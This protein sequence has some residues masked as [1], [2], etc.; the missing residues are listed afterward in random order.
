MLTFL[1]KDGFR[2]RPKGI[3]SA[4]SPLRMLALPAHTRTEVIWRLESDKGLRSIRED[5]LH[6]L[7]STRGEDPAAITTAQTIGLVMTELAGNALRHGKPPVL[8]RLL[9]DDDCHLLLDV[10]DRAI[11]RIPRQPGPQQSLSAGG[12]GL[13]IALS[14]A[15]AVCWYVDGDVK[16]VWATFPR[17][18]GR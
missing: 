7:A 11:D 13:R 17:Q 2:F 8:V 5:L 1:R 9:S 3:M 15:Q 4:M 16:H 6:H 12:R 14:V 10:S 18:G